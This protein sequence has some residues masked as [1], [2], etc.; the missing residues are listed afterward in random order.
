MDTNAA[1]AQE[2]LEALSYA[3]QVGASALDGVPVD[4]LN[5]LL[6]LAGFP[7]LCGAESDRRSIQAITQQLHREP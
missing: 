4:F 7:A 3:P 1:T 5:R 6:M 2:V